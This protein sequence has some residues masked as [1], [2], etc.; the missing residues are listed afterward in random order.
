M[1]QH[2]WSQNTQIQKSV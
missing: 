1:I 2:N